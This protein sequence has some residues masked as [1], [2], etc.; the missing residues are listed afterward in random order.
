MSTKVGFFKKIAYRFKGIPLPGEAEAPKSM[1][2]DMGREY[3]AQPLPPMPKDY[4]EHP[5]RDLVN[6]PYP[7]RFEYPPKTRFLMIPDSW[8]TPFHK[9]TGTSGIF[10]Y[11][12]LI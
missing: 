5:E 2:A 4:K 9:I 7:A 6:F 12:R 3:V 8:C 1:F 11:D 10:Y